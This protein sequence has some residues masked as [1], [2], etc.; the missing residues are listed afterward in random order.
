[1][2]CSECKWVVLL[3]GSGLMCVAGDAGG[4]WTKHEQTNKMTD[5]VTVSFELYAD[6]AGHGSGPMVAILCSQGPDGKLPVAGAMYYGDDVLNGARHSP[7]DPREVKAEVRIDKESAYTALWRQPGRYES[8]EMD[9]RTA[10]A[11][12]SA[13]T[14]LIRVLTF[15]EGS[16]ES[17]FTLTGLDL[18]QVTAACGPEPFGK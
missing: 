4:K 8:A 3:L 11:L 2:L 15:P 13:T 12:L 17:S 10:K 18:A 16:A 7:G 14:L 9:D 6:G 5:R 1:M